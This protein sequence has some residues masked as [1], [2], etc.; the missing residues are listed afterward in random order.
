MELQTINQVSKMYDISTR[1]LR[2]YEQ[3]G[4]ISSLRKEGY[5]YRVYDETAV[6]RLQQI[7]ILRKLRIPMKQISIILDRPETAE[8][9]EIFKQ[10]IDELNEEVDAL[11]TIRDVLVR[12]VENLQKMTNIRLELGA[13]FDSSILSIVS[14]LTLSKNHVKEP[15]K[16]EDFQKADEKL[17]I[18]TDNDVRIVYLPP[19]TVASVRTFGEVPIPEGKSH[20]IIEAFAKETDLFRIYPSTRNYGFDNNDI[21]DRKEIHGYEV[22]IT[23]P[24]DFEVPATLVKKSFA[25][26]LYA[27][28]KMREDFDER[29]LFNNWLIKNDDFEYDEREPVGMGGWLEEHFNSYNMYGLK[30]KKHTLTHLEFLI[31]IKEKTEKVSSPKPLKN[32]VK[33]EFDM[34]KAIDVDLATMVSDTVDTEGMAGFGKSIQKFDMSGGELVLASDG[35]LGCA[36]TAGSYTLPL[37]INLTA[38]TD[39]TNIRVY[40]QKG[41]IIFNWE[42][43]LDEL[44]V[45]DILTGKNYGY[46]GQGR[47]PKNEYVDITWVIEKD[48]HEI[49]VNGELRQKGDDYPY[50]KQLKQEPDQKISGP[51]K[52]SAAWGSIVTVKSLKVTELYQTTE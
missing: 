23:I 13:A 18:V 44:R 4:L 32:I 25:G 35:D 27:A 52:I 47:V 21:V 26:G 12:F 28:Y 15:I 43:N 40:Y 19:A 14:L 7:I 37:R 46:R 33:T 49:Y 1:M 5:S 51:V 31:P 45:H 48:T 17:R 36:Q 29:A 39:S 34:S 16:M 11:T 6:R 3:A 41:E 9:I 8:A 30:D 38:K 10:N 2:Y 50:I 24:D 20:D 42:C 22:W